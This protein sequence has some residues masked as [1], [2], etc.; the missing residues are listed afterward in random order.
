MTEKS[1]IKFLNK[2][3]SSISLLIKTLTTTVLSDFDTRMRKSTLSHLTEVD[4]AVINRNLR[5]SH[6]R[7]LL[8][9]MEE[10]ELW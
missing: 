8:T 10:I 4:L 9:V 1:L 2:F 7:A 5:I 6:E 3:E